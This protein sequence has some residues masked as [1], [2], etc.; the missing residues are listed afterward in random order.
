MSTS[1]TNAKLVLIGDS[2]I[3]NFNKSSYIFDKFFL[4]FS[5]LNFGVSIDKIQNVLSLV[6]NI[7]FP[8]PFGNLGIGMSA[9]VLAL[10][11]ASALAFEYK[12]CI[13]R[14]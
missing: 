8:G 12:H 10:A 13:N 5:T 2:I 9:S 4:R 3:E 7:T 6:C 11:L 1:S 14:L